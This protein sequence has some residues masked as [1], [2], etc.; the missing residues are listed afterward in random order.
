MQ[1][2]GT[3]PSF[4]VASQTDSLNYLAKLNGHTSPMFHIAQPK[5]KRLICLRLEEEGLCTLPLA[6]VTHLCDVDL[7]R[8]WSRWF[9]TWYTKVG[10]FQ[11]CTHLPSS[12]FRFS[13]I[14]QSLQYFTINA[15]LHITVELQNHKFANIPQSW[16]SWTDLLLLVCSP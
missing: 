8:D 4:R 3:K 5:F 7:F 2:N 14:L 1:S 9:T 13:S 15:K 11:F 6:Y 16:V 10:S 12:P